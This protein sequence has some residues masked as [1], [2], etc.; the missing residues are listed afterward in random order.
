MTGQLDGLSTALLSLLE[1]LETDEGI[2]IHVNSGF[3]DPA[4][5]AAVGGVQ[6][7]E[8]TQVPANGADVKAHTSQERYRIVKAA[9]KYGVR[10]I[11]IGKTFV[12]LGTSD[13]LWLY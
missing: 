3:R 13:V 4:H 5:N 1:R 2:P 10:R 8:H 9:L 12:H 7:S 11:G 6:A